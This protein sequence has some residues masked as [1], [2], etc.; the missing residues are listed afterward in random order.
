MV[1]A[2]PERSI[3]TSTWGTPNPFL[4]M[5]ASE[6][7]PGRRW[8]PRW[9]PLTLARL[10]LIP[11]TTIIYPPPA[12]PPAPLPTVVGSAAAL[13]AVTSDRADLRSAGAAAI[14]SPSERMRASASAHRRRGN[15]L[16]ELGHSAAAQGGS[17]RALLSDRGGAQFTRRC[18]RCLSEKSGPPSLWVSRQG[19]NGHI[20]PAS[21][22]VVAARDRRPAANTAESPTSRHHPSLATD[23]KVGRSGDERQDVG[24]ARAPRRNIEL[25]IGTADRRQPRGEMPAANR[26]G[27]LPDPSPARRD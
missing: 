4:R 25:L 22:L 27:R 24:A 26:T 13:A 2:P 3:P 14:F 20:T 7:G 17:Q 21:D 12:A 11:E 19:S 8:P 18:P 23:K 1:G 15:R 9:R 6:L 16:Q 5:G 10:Q